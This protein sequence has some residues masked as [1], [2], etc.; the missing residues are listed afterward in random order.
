MEPHLSGHP[1]ER[2]TPHERPLDT[3]N[4]NINDERLPH[5]KGYFSSV[6]GLASQ[7]HFLPPGVACTTGLSHNPFTW[8]PL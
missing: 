4:L 6:K 2:P 7:E 8:R 5:L 1:Y 3:V